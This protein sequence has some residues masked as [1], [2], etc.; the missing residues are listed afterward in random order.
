MRELLYLSRQK[1]AMFD[2]PGHDNRQTEWQHEFKSRWWRTRF[3]RSRAKGA[4]DELAR[5]REVEADLERHPI[6]D[7]ADPAVKPNQWVGFDLDLG[8]G[9]AT[10]TALM[11]FPTMSSSSSATKALRI[12][13]TTSVSSS[14]DRS[15]ICEI[16]PS[17]RQDGWAQEPTG[18]TG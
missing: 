18:C 13:H 9:T 10:M 11:S 14:L 12:D 3:T 15:T 5:L 16:D 4:P 8:Y 2:L 6:P 1:L 17:P 7:F